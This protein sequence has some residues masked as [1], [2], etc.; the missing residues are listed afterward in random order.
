[1]QFLLPLEIMA[2]DQAAASVYGIIRADLEKQGNIIGLMDI[3]IAAH[4]LSLGLTLVT[5]NLR[6][7]SRIPNLSLENW[8]E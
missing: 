4:A 8:A 7:F 3:L 6:E 2:F 1:M 5:N